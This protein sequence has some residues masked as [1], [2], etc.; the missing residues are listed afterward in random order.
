MQQ[1]YGQQQSN[2]SHVATSIPMWG[3]QQAQQPS[4]AVPTVSVTISRT[5]PVLLGL[6]VSD[7]MLVTGVQPGGLAQQYGIEKYI[8][9]RISHVNN[10]ACNN[11]EEVRESRNFAQTTL[12]FEPPVLQAPPVIPQYPSEGV[13]QVPLYPY[14]PPA[15]AAPVAELEP[16]VVPLKSSLDT[17]RYTGTVKSFNTS[18]G[19][20]F[21]RCP[22]LYEEHKRDVFIHKN[23]ASGLHPKDTVRFSIEMNKKNMPQAAFVEKIKDGK[24]AKKDGKK[25]Q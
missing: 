5:I 15:D 8:G 17:T 2:Q 11:V 20:G 3:Q 9:W 1:S 14:S 10:R 12:S 23:H 6:E 21:I 19:F 7:N 25:K 18:T 24:T 16:P 13:T 22:Q 4:Q